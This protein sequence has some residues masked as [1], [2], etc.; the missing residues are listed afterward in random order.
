MDKS[1]SQSGIKTSDTFCSIVVI[2]NASIEKLP[3]YKKFGTTLQELSDKDYPNKYKFR[4]DVKSINVDELKCALFSGKAI[5][6][7]DAIIGVSDYDDAKNTTFNHRLLLIE[8]R[9]GYKTESNF[10]R[11]DLIGKVHGTKKCLATN[12][13]YEKSIL[14]IFD[15]CFIQRA[16]N[17]FNRY[18]NQGGDSKFFYAYSVSEFNDTVRDL[19]DNFVYKAKFNQKDILNKLKEYFKKGDFSGLYKSVNYWIET[20]KKEKLHYNI[21]EYNNIVQALSE[22]KTYF[23]TQEADQ[24][25]DEYI[26]LFILFE[27]EI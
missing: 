20:A 10:S 21:H 8:F 11:N 22:F 14:F 19:N 2:N 27:D 5:K 26:K 7:V 9:M 24:N 13:K 15:N 17:L 6:S 4:H 23:Y 3:E 16:K 1:F 18:R 25:S 12:N